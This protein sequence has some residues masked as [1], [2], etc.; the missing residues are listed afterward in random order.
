MP[1]V[2]EV[3]HEMK[4][5][6]WYAGIIYANPNDKRV[7]VPRRPA[8]TGWTIN[9]GRPMTWFLLGV[10]LALWYFAN[11]RTHRADETGD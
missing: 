6:G 7:V 11:R 4:H 2:S 10:T 8:W 1:D 9:F 3:I 5:D